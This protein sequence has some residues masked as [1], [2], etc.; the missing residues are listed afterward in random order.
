MD[1]PPAILIHSMEN[2]KIL[3][4]KMLNGELQSPS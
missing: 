4:N 1:D 3:F 2:E